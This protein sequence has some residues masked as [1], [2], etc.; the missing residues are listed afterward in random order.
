MK[1]TENGGDEAEVTKTSDD[2]TISSGNLTLEEILSTDG[3]T[4]L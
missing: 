1:G 3:E 4:S 2:K